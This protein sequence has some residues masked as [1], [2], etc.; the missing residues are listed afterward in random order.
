MGMMVG[1]GLALVSWGLAKNLSNK[2][3]QGG[4]IGGVGGGVGWWSDGESGEKH[5]SLV[6]AVAGAELGNTN[7][8]VSRYIII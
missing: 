7:I 2:F 8:I 1:L 3:C 4:W 5:L 6:E